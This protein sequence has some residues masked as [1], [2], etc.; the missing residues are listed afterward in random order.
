MVIMYTFEKSESQGVVC[1]KAMGRAHYGV[2]N[3]NSH[4]LNTLIEHQGSTI[5]ILIRLVHGLNVV[6]FV[7]S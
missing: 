4:W 7:I 6:F 2:T 5:D 3:S 1:R